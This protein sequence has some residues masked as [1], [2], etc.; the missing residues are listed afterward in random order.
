MLESLSDIQMADKYH[1]AKQGLFIDI[2]VG[3]DHY[4]KRMENGFI[5]LGECP[6]ALESKYGWVLSGSYCG[7]SPTLSSINSHR[8]LS[9]SDVPESTSRDFLNLESLGIRPKENID[10][11]VDLVMERFN[12][13]TYF[14]GD[15]Y[16]VS[17]PWKPQ[18]PEL[19]NNLKSVRV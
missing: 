8:L 15:R 19:Q 4:W 11:N 16:V 6:V 14:D 18:R 7:P 13:S 1:T 10:D 17:L 12:N 9:L 3:L 2:F 5:R